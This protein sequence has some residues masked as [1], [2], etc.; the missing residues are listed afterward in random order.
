MLSS[1]FGT[2][3]MLEEASSWCGLQRVESRGFAYR[4]ERGL[5]GKLEPFLYILELPLL[6]C[7]DNQIHFN[8]RSDYV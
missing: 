1:G 6:S 8:L 5:K 2:S 7:D 3:M 4:L